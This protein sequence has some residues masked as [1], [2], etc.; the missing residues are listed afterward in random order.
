VRND[1]HPPLLNPDWYE[2]WVEETR[3]NSPTLFQTLLSGTPVRPPFSIFTPTGHPQAPV[4]IARL[5]DT[6]K[7]LGLN[8]GVLTDPDLGLA[9]YANGNFLSRDTLFADFALPRRGSLDPSFAVEPF[10]TGFRRYRKKIA[11]GESVDHFVTEGMLF[12]SLADAVGEAAVPAG[13]WYLDARVHQDYARHLLPRAVAYSA[14]LLD[15]FFRGQLTLFFF[16]SDPLDPRRV[17]LFLANGGPEPLAGTAALY[18]EDGTGTRALLRDLGAVALAPGAFATL[19]EV[20]LPAGAT[21]W[22]VVVRGTQGGEVGAVLGKVVPALTLDL[23]AGNITTP[24]LTPAAGVNVQ[25]YHLGHQARFTVTLT[26]GAGQPADLP[27]PPAGL[28]GEARF[29]GYQLEASFLDQAVTGDLTRTGPGVYSFTTAPLARPD[30]GG[31]GP[32]DHRF[33]VRVLGPAGDILAGTAAELLVVAPV[34]AIAIERVL[35]PP[36]QAVGEPYLTSQR[37]R[38]TVRFRGPEAPGGPLVPLSPVQMSPSDP[39]VIT[40]AFPQAFTATEPRSAFAGVG[41]LEVLET[42][43]TVADRDRALFG[44]SPW[45]FRVSLS[46]RD[47]A[48]ENLTQTDTLQVNPHLRL[49]HPTT[50]WTPATGCG[51][52]PPQP[53]TWT[54]DYQNVLVEEPAPLVQVGLR[55]TFANGLDAEGNCVSVGIN[56][57]ALV[58][59]S[60][61]GNGSYTGTFTGDPTATSVLFQYWG[62]DSQG[63]L[64]SLGPLGGTV[65]FPPGAFTGS[66]IP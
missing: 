64:V 52:A 49:A 53:A 36:Q 55:E 42:E 15:A 44:L 28:P 54:V 57:S 22:V 58:T 8:V 9:E 43:L 30:N 23:Q 31:A 10:G 7:F 3:E 65:L 35:L 29:A 25:F 18:T 12:D 51:P 41:V 32:Q 46:Q 1:A 14:G 21:G 39:N 62:E 16:R 27:V 19:G 5:I 17:L 37:P 34:T 66:R 63:Y 13:G 2:D 4:P 59:L 26:D 40:L 47:T 11:E 61:S 24:A 33:R 38:F 6:D 60:G 48:Y 20:A 56:N 50:T 45:T